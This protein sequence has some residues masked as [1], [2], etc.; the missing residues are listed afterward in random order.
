[1]CEDISVQKRRR[2]RVF[3]GSPFCDMDGT[4]NEASCLVGT[5]ETPSL[6]LGPLTQPPGK[7]QQIHVIIPSKHE[8]RDPASSTDIVSDIRGMKVTAKAIPF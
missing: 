1:V 6:V 3:R 8:P 4:E 2:S 7:V 5:T